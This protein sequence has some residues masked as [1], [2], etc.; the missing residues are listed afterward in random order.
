M[1]VDQMFMIV[2]NS[3]LLVTA[4]APTAVAPTALILWLSVI[5][6]HIYIDILKMMIPVD[7]YTCVDV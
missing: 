6:H 3:R 1:M 5:S 7:L 2:H 4:V